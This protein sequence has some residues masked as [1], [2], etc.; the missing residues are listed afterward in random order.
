MLTKIKNKKRRKPLKDEDVQ[1]LQVL[2]DM[3][4]RWFPFDYNQNYFESMQ[5]LIDSWP[6]KSFAKTKSGQ[7]FVRFGYITGFLMCQ[8]FHSE[9]DEKSKI[10]QQFL[11]SSKEEQKKL[12]NKYKLKSLE[13]NFD[14]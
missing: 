9:V 7:E 6:T 3:A 10:I 8:R 12:L 1:F 13:P 5:D 11:K 4:Y 14:F 2:N